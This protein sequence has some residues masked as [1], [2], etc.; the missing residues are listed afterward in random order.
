MV[1]LERFAKTLSSEEQEV[2]DHLRAFIEWYVGREGEF[3]PSSAD[4]VAL[5]TYLLQMKMNGAS[6]K[7]QGEHVASL[8]R[9]Y[10][11]AESAGFLP[12]YHPFTEF[13]ID[14]PS[15]TR[16]QIRR[17]KEIFPG[18]PEE[19]EISRLRA[20]NHLAEQLNR[21]SDVQTTLTAALETLVSLMRLQTAWA[22][23]LPTASS[24]LISVS[25]SSSDRFSLAAACGLPPGLEKND[26][27]Y[28][29]NVKLCH[30]QAV[31]LDGN[32]KRAV[33]IVECTRLQEA[34]R[35]SGDNQG[36]MFHASVPIIASG[37][38]LG[39]MN[40]ATQDWQF[41]TAA[42]LQLLS[43]VG[44]QVAIAL[45]R[46]RLYDVTHAQRLRLE[47][48]LKLA[49]EIQDSLLPEAL[50]QVPSFSLAA[51]WR[52]ALEMAGDFYDIFPLPEGR[53]GIVVADV[54]DKG[55]AAAMYMAM[56]RSLIRASASNYSNPAGTL[57]EV[58]Q[59]LL[60][61][62]T[63]DMFVTVFYAVLDAETQTLIYANA[64]QNP[65]LLRH[66]SGEIEKLTRTGVAL[67]VLEEST[68]SD[69]SLILAPG[70]SLVI[71][72]DGVTDA[73]NPQGEEYGITRLAEALLNA[74]PSDARRLLDYLTGGLAAF[75]QDVP[76][77]DDIT[78]F[79]LINEQARLFSLH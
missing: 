56:T 3:I 25:V 17:R 61:H 31:M 74:P 13:S 49:R 19:R 30:C 44:A 50:P 58:N 6:T 48:E 18:S 38:A 67:G 9:F 57:N 34:A 4:D 40:V 53:W 71:Y 42:D 20:L 75:T 35:A 15:L 22:F 52:S 77:F 5:R 14:R 28:L 47:R 43:A 24:P 64:G 10:D 72:T 1:V 55:A 32:L 70:D 60:A 66:I 65:P 41:L 62:S 33:N 11:W 78:F 39:I 79:I 2:L 69:A 27:H 54:S 12:D 76:P 37:Q 63:S 29:K 23:L 16:E 45:E 73:L 7:S 68:L 21:S 8:R 36:L 59:R 26:R 46:A 51:D